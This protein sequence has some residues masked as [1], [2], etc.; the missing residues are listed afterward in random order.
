[1]HDQTTPK[2]NPAKKHYE[3]PRLE[4]FG[5]VA[6]LTNAIGTSGKMDG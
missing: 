3:P 6:F 4:R 1:M 2:R 5:D